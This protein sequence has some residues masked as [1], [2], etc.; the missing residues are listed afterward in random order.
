MSDPVYVGIE[1]TPLR[2]R[3]EEVCFA[4]LAIKVPQKK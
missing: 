3:D 2:D 1:V 4:M